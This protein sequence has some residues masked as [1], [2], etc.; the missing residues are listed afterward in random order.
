MKQV[1]C[2]RVGLKHFRFVKNRNEIDVKQLNKKR[3][4]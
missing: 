1:S 4:D 3:L 2:D